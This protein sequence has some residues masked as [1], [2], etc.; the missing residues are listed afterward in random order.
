MSIKLRDPTASQV[1]GLMA[2]TTTTQPLILLLL[3][4]FTTV[5]NHNIKIS[6]MPDTRYVT[7]VKGVVNTGWELLVKGSGL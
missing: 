6:D 5:M 4:L 2:S 3:H 7:P 1:L